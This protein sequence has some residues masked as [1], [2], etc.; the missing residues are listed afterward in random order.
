[1]SRPKR[2][3]DDRGAG[4]ALRHHLAQARHLAELPLER[5]RH[6]RGHHLRARARIEGLNL[7]RRIVDLGQ[8][9]ERQEAKRQNADEQ[10]RDHQET[11]RDRTID[12]D[13]GGIHRP[14]PASDRVVIAPGLASAPAGA[15]VRRCR[16][17]RWRWSAAR[18]ALAALGRRGGRRSRL[19]VAAAEPSALRLAVAM[20]M[21]LAVAA[22]R[23]GRPGLFMP[24]RGRLRRGA[25]R[26]VDDLDLR[27]VAQT[28]DAVDHHLVAGLEARGDHGVACRRSAR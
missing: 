4:G 15:G 6:R 1:M 26:V 23:A 25:R 18:P 14:A 16:R 8:G 11:G 17:L 27:A 28:V 7:D 10:N 24:L 5:R 3:R 22:R 2:K 21:M 12:E 19:R 13:A 20:A 9:R